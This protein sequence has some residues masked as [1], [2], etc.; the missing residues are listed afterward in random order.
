M[1]M[2]SNPISD[3]SRPKLQS[4]V[5][6]GF[7]VNNVDAD[8]K[9]QRQRIQVRIPQHHRNISDAD[10]PWSIPD[11]TQGSNNVAVSGG[12]QVGNVTIPPIGSKVYVRIEENDPHNPR[13]SGSPSTDDVAKGNELLDENYPHTQGSI[14]L[15]NNRSSV[16]LEKQTQ[17]Q[18]HSSGTTVHI[19]ANGTMSISIAGDYD[20]GVKGN[21]NMVAGGEI[22]MNGKK[23]NLNEGSKTPSSPTS[24]KRP[25]VK[26]PAGQVNY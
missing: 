17:Q 24:R 13:Y 16:N 19:A 3:L 5:L 15:A 18:T 25:Q 2:L 9:K 7:V 1:P 8:D 21:I 12:S 10:L 14:D 11:T 22:N 20:I 26:S 6:I 23:I 4:N